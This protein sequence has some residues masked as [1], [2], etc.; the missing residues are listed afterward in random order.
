MKGM[1]QAIASNTSE[2]GIPGSSGP[3]KYDGLSG[4]R[5]SVL[6]EVRLLFFLS[7]FIFKSMRC[8]TAEQVMNGTARRWAKV[9]IVE[10][11]LRRLFIHRCDAGLGDLDILF[12]FSTAEC[13]NNVA[14]LTGAHHP[15]LPAQFAH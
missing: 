15:T 1:R 13:G 14:V 12:R 7:A 4:W 6:P 8:A 2:R 9:S 10:S 11:C 5:S 3:R